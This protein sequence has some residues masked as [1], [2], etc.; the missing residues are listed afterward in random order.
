[1]KE[2]KLL[3]CRRCQ[4]ELQLHSIAGLRHQLEL[5]ELD[6][7]RGAVAVL[8]E[9]NACDAVRIPDPCA[10]LAGSN[11]HLPVRGPLQGGARAQ[12]R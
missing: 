6:L 1:M 11:A 9:K 4:C 10:G 12:G 8:L 2:E 5:V 7:V 3:R